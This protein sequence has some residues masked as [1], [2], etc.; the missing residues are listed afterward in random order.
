MIE[1]RLDP[2]PAELDARVRDVDEPDPFVAGGDIWDVNPEH[3]QAFF[4][5]FQVEIV[6]VQHDGSPFRI[7]D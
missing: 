3:F 6:L 4:E 5:L 1:F 7:D 2:D